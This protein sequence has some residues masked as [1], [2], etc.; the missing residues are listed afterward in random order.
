LARYPRQETRLP[1][2]L[3][4]PMPSGAI[5][6]SDRVKSDGVYTRTVN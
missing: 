5:L 1:V 3:A 2:V 6:S 4:G